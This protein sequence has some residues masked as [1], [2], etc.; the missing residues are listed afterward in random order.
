MTPKSRE[1][2]YWAH[3]KG[4]RVLDEQNRESAEKRMASTT[5]EQR[6]EAVRKAHANMTPE[7]RASRAEKIRLGHAARTP[8]QKRQH[9]EAVSRARRGGA[10]MRIVPVGAWGWQRFAMGLA[11]LGW[12]C[13]VCKARENA[14]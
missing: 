3:E 4:Y 7:Q 11:E 12:W 13:P 5:P 2:I 1:A 8:E 9:G 6:S 10:H 14:L